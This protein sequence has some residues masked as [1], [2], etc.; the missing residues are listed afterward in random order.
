[1]HVKSPTDFEWLKQSR[2]YF[3]EE[4]DKC[5]ISITDVDFVYQNEYLGCTDRLV[6]TPL[7]DRSVVEGRVH[8]CG[9]ENVQ[10]KR[11]TLLRFFVILIRISGFVQKCVKVYNCGLFG[12]D[13]TNVISLHT[14]LWLL[15]CLFGLLV[16][17]T[18]SNECVHASS[19]NMFENS[20]DKFPLGWV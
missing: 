5:V 6:I 2:F 18:L 19:V 3:R 12:I 14:W 15:Y 13:D 16:I 8:V 9:T 7:T 17:I 20:V 1:M 4:E 11:Y 10:L